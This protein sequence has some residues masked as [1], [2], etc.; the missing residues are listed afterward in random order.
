[1]SNDLNDL[2]E[3]NGSNL[4]PAKDPCEEGVDERLCLHGTNNW[5]GRCKSG[6]SA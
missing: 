5:L 2:K 1:M 4:L 3:A 6:G